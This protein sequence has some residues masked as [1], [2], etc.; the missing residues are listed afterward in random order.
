V[1]I[2]D[3]FHHSEA[4]RYTTL[5]EHVRPAELLGLTAHPER[6]DGLDV[7]HWFDDRIAA[8]LECGTPST[9]TTSPRS[10]TSG[11]TMAS[12]FGT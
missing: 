7:L 10:P 2:V 9:S 5:F 4:R 8:E 3:E 1:V 12:T 6:S 11:F